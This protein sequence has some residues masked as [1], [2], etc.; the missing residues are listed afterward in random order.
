MSA[1]AVRPEPRPANAG[2][3]PFLSPQDRRFGAIRCGAGDNVR[4]HH[5]LAWK[6]NGLTPQERFWKYVRKTES[7]WLWEAS[8]FPKGYGCFSYPGSKSQ[9]AHRH[10]Y[11]MAYGPIPDGKQIDHLCKVT[12][13]V[14]PDHLEAVTQY[15]NNMRSDSP[16]AINAR[17]VVCKH[18]HP[19]D[20]IDLQGKRRCR[21]CQRNKTRAWRL[22][23]ELNE[24][25]K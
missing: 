23:K 15:E 10:S 19:F 8:R 11:E 25:A 4:K 9:R 17:R 13:C 6:N 2:D 7:C 20:F 24:R 3:N 22:R 16:V 14:R 12:R 5:P 18:G 1:V 21:T